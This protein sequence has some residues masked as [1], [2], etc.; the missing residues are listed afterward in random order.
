MNAYAVFVLAALVADLV[1]ERVAD[2]LNLKALHREPPEE[3]QGLYDEEEYARSQAY[4]RAHTRL[5]IVSSTFGFVVLLAFWL[6]GGFDALDLW[7]RSLGSVGDWGPVGR[8]LLYLGILGF[9]ASLLSLPFSIYST[10]VI[11]ERFGFNRT[12]VRTFVLDLVKSFALGIVLG[13]PLLAAILWLF[14]SMG[15]WAWAICWAVAA[16]YSLLVQWLAPRWLL[17]LFNELEPLEDGELRDAVT[18]YIRSEG[19]DVDQ[20]SVMDASKRSSKANAFFTGF[21]H[22]KRLTLFDTLVDTLDVDETVAVV[23]HEMGHYRRGH[24]WRWL[25]L[26]LAHQG[27]VLY[28]LSYFLEQPGLY[29]A[30]FM[31]HTPLYAG[32]VFFGLLMTPLER[33]LG[34]GLNALSRRQEYEADRYAVETTQDPESLASGLRKIAADHLSNLTPHRLQVL[35]RY[36]HPPLHRRLRRLRRLRHGA[37]AG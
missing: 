18:R 6:L 17:P 3:L 25:A 4:T 28:L 30:F 36:S 37:S 11:E 29:E 20:V 23:A 19:Y 26:G 35:L 33:F 15:T 1:V 7:L 5:G 27:V 31:T 8:G 32:F 34:L 14:D 21:G 24:L 9:G 10:F 2:V 12:T 16:V 22:T 13:G